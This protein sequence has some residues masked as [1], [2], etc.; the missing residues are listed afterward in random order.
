MRLAFRALVASRA[1][2]KR[3][4]ARLTS[5]LIPLFLRQVE[6]RGG[7]VDAL[8]RRF[9]LRNDA[10]GE[11]EPMLTLAD[12]RAF[13][14][15]AAEAARLP[16]LGLRSAQAAPRGHYGVL[17]FIARSARDVHGGLQGLIRYSALVSEYLRFDLQ[18]GPAEAVLRVHV[19]HEPQLAG[20][21][22]NEFTLALF[23]RLIRELSETSFA[24]RRIWFG[25]STPSNLEALQAFFQTTDVSFD[26]GENGMQF[27]AHVLDRRV[28]T[29][30]DA[31][32][33]V[34]E[35]QAER[36]RGERPAEEDFLGKVRDAIRRTLGQGEVGIDQVAT[37][38]YVSERTLQRRLE[39]HGTSFKALV[40]DVRK[41]TATLLLEGSQIGLGEVA[42]RLGYSDLRSF[43]RAFKR[44][45]GTTPGGYR[46]RAP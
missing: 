9:G 5:H 3:S 42:F 46:Q 4:G 39:E 40:D 12:F 7:D 23:T 17:E 19:Q 24:P 1:V 15:A 33:A 44:W 36:I 37:L 41:T 22:A 14:E 43:T 27:D 38:L 31:L 11:V 18:R 30:D 35:Q 45:T 13:S 10:S 8:I 2:A 6:Q 28:C 20:R 29:A 32:H 26:K 16:E 21:H 34:L 25:H